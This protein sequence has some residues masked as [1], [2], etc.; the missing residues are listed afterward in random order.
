MGQKAQFA[1]N[2]KEATAHYIQKALT[3]FDRGLALPRV[4]A[5]I[6]QLEEHCVK[7][8][9]PYDSMCRLHATIARAGKKAHVE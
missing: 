6:M 1:A 5:A 2:S 7:G 3:V 9:T 4:S 8:R